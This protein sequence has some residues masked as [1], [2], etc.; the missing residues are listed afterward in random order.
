MNTQPVD[1]ASSTDI[2]SS[3][4]LLGNVGTPFVIGLA[5]GY[6][7]KKMLRTVLFLGGAAIVLLFVAEY[8]DVIDITDEKLQHAAS[9]ATE[10]AKSSGGFL[11]DRLTSVTS[12]GASGVGGFFVGFKLG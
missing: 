10:A 2:F 9:A 12:K 7:A 4:F 5:V 3:A 6:F 11:V 8:Y 1:A